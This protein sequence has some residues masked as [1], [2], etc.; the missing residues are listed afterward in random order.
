MESEEY[1][2]A[3]I[4]PAH[5]KRRTACAKR[6]GSTPR[7]CT[8]PCL[9]GVGESGFKPDKKC[10]NADGKA[11]RH[12]TSWPSAQLSPTSQGRRAAERIQSL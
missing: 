8:H 7:Y 3:H 11:V 1:N 12:K 6:M 5:P 9:F 4:Y 2:T 10:I